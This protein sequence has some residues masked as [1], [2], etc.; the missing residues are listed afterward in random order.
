[1]LALSTVL[2]TAANDAAATGGMQS[3]VSIA[4]LVIVFVAFYFFAIRPQKK[5]EREQ[6]NMRN[7]LCVGDEITTIGGILGRVTKITEETV[8]IETSRERTK[9]HILKTAIRS[10]DVHA[11]DT[12]EAA[13]KAAKKAELAEA[14]AKDK[15]EKAAKKAEL[16]E[17]K[18]KEKEKDAWND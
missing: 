18:E 4:M 13:E 1:M 11:E 9:M 16:A 15:E 3:W 10:V 12:V 14:N 8:V 17:A 2:E 7:S 6:N 5:Q